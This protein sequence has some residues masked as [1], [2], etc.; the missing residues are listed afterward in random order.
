M[1]ALL[2]SH[3]ILKV[4]LMDLLRARFRKLVWM[5]ASAILLASLAPTLSTW[6]HANSPAGQAWMEICSA[7][8]IT[9]V[10]ANGVLG[11]ARKPDAP[12]GEHAQKAHCPFCL[13]QAHHMGLPPA[14]P[15][16]FIRGDLAMNL[17]ELFLQAPQPLFVWAAAQ[18]RAPPAQA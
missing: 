18:A 12:P 3:R 10:A 6:A 16:P 14:E 17:P 2:L 4:G 1:R 7:S 9:K 8:A 11:D 13:L 15:K 5:A